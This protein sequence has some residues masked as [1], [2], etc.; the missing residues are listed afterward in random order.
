MLFSIENAFEAVISVEPNARSVQQ[1]RVLAFVLNEFK[2]LN[3]RL[4]LTNNG[5]Y[6]NAYVENDWGNALLHLK[7]GNKATIVV[8]DQSGSSLRLYFEFDR[9]DEK[10][11]LADATSNSFYLKKL[12]IDY[13]EMAY[14]ES[15]QL[16]IAS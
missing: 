4:D 6:T 11:I 16:C 13:M 9:T 7:S 10:S 8:L 1:G 5:E 12:A 14:K 2:N 3:L 15:A